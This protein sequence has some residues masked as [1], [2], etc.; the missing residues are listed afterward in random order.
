[1][2]SFSCGVIH[3]S[4]CFA[5][6]LVISIVKDPYPPQPVMQSNADLLPPLRE[7]N[8]GGLIQVILFNQICI[9]H[10]AWQRTYYVVC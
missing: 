5:G 6:R 3:I 7:V 4:L 10:L 8:L 9:K 2:K 1:M